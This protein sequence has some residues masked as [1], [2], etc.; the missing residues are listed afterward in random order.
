MC[1]VHTS[2]VLHLQSRWLM[3]STSKKLCRLLCLAVK[4]PRWKRKGSV[5]FFL[6]YASTFPTNKGSSSFI[7]NQ[8]QLILITVTLWFIQ[9]HTCNCLGR[10]SSLCS[11]LGPEFQKGQARSWSQQVLQLLTTCRVGQ[12]MPPGFQ[13]TLPLPRALSLSPTSTN[14]SW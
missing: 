3:P 7:S 6:C 9:T 8:F 12:L 13:T 14:Y 5:C 11:K 10:F 4:P 1:S 2:V